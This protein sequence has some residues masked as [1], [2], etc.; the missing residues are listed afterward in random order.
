MR[1]SSRLISLTSICLPLL[2]TACASKPPVQPPA[3]QKVISGDQMLR[4]SQGIQ[5][6]GSRWQQG[7]QMVDKGQALQTQGQAQIDQG[8]KM[9]NDG[10][11]IM[12]ESEESYKNIKQ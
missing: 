9:I 8:Q 3:P 4:D 7:K 12:Q 2:L 10:Q 5:Q 1:K 6:L 11:A